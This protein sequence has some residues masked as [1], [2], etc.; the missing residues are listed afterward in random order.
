MKVGCCWVMYVPN[1]H[2][3]VGICTYI[4]A[5]EREAEWDARKASSVGLRR[6][7]GRESWY[8]TDREPDERLD[9]DLDK[10]VLYL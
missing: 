5:R 4:K 9:L 8:N 10:G 1:L 6:L 7:V 3:Y 2:M